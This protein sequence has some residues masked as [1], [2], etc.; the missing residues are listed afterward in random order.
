MNSIVEGGSGTGKT[1]L[2]TFLFKLL[3]SNN[4]DFNFKEFGDQE[5]EFI[6]LVID[7]KRKYPNPK[8]ALVI[9]MPSFRNTIK[10]VFRNIK[11]LSSNMVIGPAEVVKGKF[12]II[13]VD[14]SHRLRRR[15]NLGAYFGAFDI[16][17]R[18]LNLDKTKCNELDWIIMQSENTILFYDDTQSVK[19][20]DIKKEDFDK[21]KA[22]KFTKIEYLNSQIRVKGGTNYVQFVDQLLKCSLHATKKI[23]TKNYEFF[24]F[25]SIKEMER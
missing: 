11:G 16:A 17:C 21:L 9:P 15:V 7:L 12:D 5:A 6:N 20:S 2:A 25:D 22:N 19:P 10:K 8:M 4:G 14:E 23:Q 13:M 3:N 24:F 18:K 1:I